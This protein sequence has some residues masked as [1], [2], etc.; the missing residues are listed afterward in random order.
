MA[1][2][3]QSDLNFV[4]TRTPR[5]IIKRLKDGAGMLYL[6]GGF[7]RATIAGEKPTDIDLFAHNPTFIEQVATSL[8]AERRAR[9][10]KTQNAITVLSPPRIPVQFITRWTFDF[11]SDLVF[12]FDFTICRAAIW[13]TLVH[14][15]GLNEETKEK[16]PAKYQFHSMIDNNFYADLAAR[17]LVYT[18]P[19]RIEEAGGSLMRMIKFIKK[20]YNIQAPSIAGLIARTVGGIDMAQVTKDAVR[21]SRDASV[22]GIYQRMAVSGM[23][24]LR[25]HLADHPV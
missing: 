4:L 1:A 5:D 10:H 13:A 22:E 23:G 24:M 9:M 12:S 2:L 14:P 6:A 15:A 17:R 7:I 18:S 19:R 3:T 20:G 11:V 25:V 8:T 16:H 21:L